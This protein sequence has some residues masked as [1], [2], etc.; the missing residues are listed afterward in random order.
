MLAVAA[1]M[2]RAGP[3]NATVL[4]TGESGTGKEMVA[5]QIIGRASGGRS[6]SSR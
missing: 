5:W 3:T 4:I 2:V 1:D 6:P